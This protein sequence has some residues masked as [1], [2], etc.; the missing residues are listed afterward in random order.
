VLVVCTIL[1][2]VVRFSIEIQIMLV[3]LG[4]DEC[5]HAC[6]ACEQT[7]LTTSSFTNGGEVPKKYL[8]LQKITLDLATI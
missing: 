3:C 7:R 6:P 5:L 2:S 8:K 4:V 1:D